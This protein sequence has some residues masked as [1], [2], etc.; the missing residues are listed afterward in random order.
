MRTPWF[1]HV[2]ALLPAVAVFVVL[3]YAVSWVT[4]GVIFGLSYG[5]VATLAIYR[6][7]RRRTARRSQQSEA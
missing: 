7:R 6:M 3:G 1:V 4:A 5:F 2:L